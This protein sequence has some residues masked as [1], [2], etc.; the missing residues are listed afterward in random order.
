MT[1]T[2]CPSASRARFAVTVF[3]CHL[4]A[5]TGLAAFAGALD[6]FGVFAADAVRLRARRGRHAAAA[7]RRADGAFARARRGLR[8]VFPQPCVPPTPTLPRSSWTL[9]SSQQSWSWPAAALCRRTLRRLPSSEP[10]LLG[11][12]SVLAEV[13]FDRGLASGLSP[14]IFALRAAGLVAADLRPVAFT[15][16]VVLASDSADLDVARDLD[17]ADLAS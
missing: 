4:G 13:A 17:V 2:P 12:E 5:R 3:G 11:C 9:P 7:W 8:G 10:K 6:A 14:Q 1:S 15:A 16:L